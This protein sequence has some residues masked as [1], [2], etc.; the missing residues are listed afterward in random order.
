MWDAPLDEVQPGFLSILDP[1]PAKIVPPDG[2]N[3]TGRR[4]ALANWLTDPE[5]PLTARVMVNR[6]WHLSLR[7]RHRRH[8]RAISAS[9]ANGRRNPQLLDYLAATFVENGWSIKKLH[10]QIML[11][12]TYQHSSAVSARGGANRSR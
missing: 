1:N 5:N 2:L 4:T 11:S 3:S 9:W 7:T 6:I 10:R 8:A 12:N